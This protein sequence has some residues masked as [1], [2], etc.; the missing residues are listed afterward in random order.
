MRYYYLWLRKLL[1]FCLIREYGRGKTQMV[2][3]IVLSDRSFTT[4]FD[5][6]SLDQSY[7]RFSFHPKKK[8]LFLFVY[9]VLAISL[10]NAFFYYFFFSS[11][12]S[13]FSRV[14]FFSFFLSLLSAVGCLYEGS[15]LTLVHFFF[16]LNP[17][18][19]PSNA[20]VFKT[21]RDLLTDGQ[22]WEL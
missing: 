4:P 10:A 3:K 8:N 17:S 16:F 6:F 13:A 15:N 7:I 22:D 11:L 14:P 18:F 21:W 20:Y 19:F 1:I 12:S 9:W 5:L 2:G